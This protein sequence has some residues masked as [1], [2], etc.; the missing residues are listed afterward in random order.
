M[1]AHERA[2]CTGVV[3]MDVREQQVADVREPQPALGETLLE[4]LT[5]RRRPAVEQREAVVGLDEVDADRSLATG[6]VQ[7]DR[8]HVRYLSACGGRTLHE[9]SLEIRDQVVGRLD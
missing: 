2:G 6:E 8:L 3:E 5:R 7:I 4:R 1:V 9:G